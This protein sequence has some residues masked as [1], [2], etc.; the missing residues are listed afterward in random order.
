LFERACFV[1][2][3]RQDAAVLFLKDLHVRAAHS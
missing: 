3:D 2:A 1:R